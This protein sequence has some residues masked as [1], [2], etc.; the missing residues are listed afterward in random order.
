ME[1]N[2]PSTTAAAPIRD[3]DKR[4]TGVVMVF[5]DITERRKA[6]KQVEISEAALPAA[7]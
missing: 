1:L 4:V 2:G 7:L 5:H 3:E 6:E